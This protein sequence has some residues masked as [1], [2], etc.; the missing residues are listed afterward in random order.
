[1]PQAMNNDTVIEFD[2]FGDPTDPTLLLIMGYT[3]QMIAWQVDFCEQLAAAGHHVVR[4][5]NRDCGLSSKTRGQ[6]PNVMALMMAYISGSP[7][8]DV[9]YSLSDMADD[10]V[11][12]LDALSIEQA[13][14]AGASMGGMIT[15]QLTID[16]PNRVASMTSIMSTTG[17]PDVGQATPEAL[18]ALL[19]VPPTNRA[20]AIESGVEAGRI[21]CGPLFDE[22]LA[23][24]ALAAAYDRS[25]YP[26]G[27]AFQLAAVAKTGNR[28]EALRGVSHRALVI[29]GQADLLITPSGGE[30]TAEAIPNAN[31]L[32]LEEMG[33]DLPRP[34]WDTIV[35]A[36]TAHTIG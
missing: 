14:V 15:Q 32:M 13:H 28:T 4:F 1:M 29:H 11:A 16:H 26:A 3:A 5:D 24:E 19:R 18:E 33:H 31:L 7:V 35:G 25:F 30:A 10:A 21:I 17:A 2:S 8:G 27:A 34:L 6:A 22:D 9:P 12:V 23:R 20:E 36:I